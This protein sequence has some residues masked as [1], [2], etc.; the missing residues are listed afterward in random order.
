MRYLICL[1]FFM[2]FYGSSVFAA[3]SDCDR[4]ASPTGGGTGLTE[5]S[6]FQIIDFWPVIMLGSVDKLCLI[7]GTYTGANSMIDPNIASLSGTAVN[8]ITIE[9]I[10]HGGCYI[11]GEG[12]RRPIYLNENSYFHIIGVNA[13]DSSENVVTLGGSAVP[14][15]SIIEKGV[16]WDMGLNF[17]GGVIDGGQTNNARISD[18]AVWGVGR[19]SLSTIHS[20]NL[21][22]QRCWFRWEGTGVIGTTKT[23]STNRGTETGMILENIIATV[24][25]DPAIPQNG[26]YRGL[27]SDTAVNPHIANH[28]LLGSIGLYPSDAGITGQAAVFHRLTSSFMYENIAVFVADNIPAETDSFSFVNQTP[29]L[30]NV[31]LDGYTSIADNPPVFGSDYFTGSNSIT[32]GDECGSNGVGCS[33]IFTSSVG[34]LIC[35]KYEDGVQTAMPLWPLP[36]TQQ[37]IDAMDFAGETPVDITA[38]VESIFGTIPSQCRSDTPSPSPPPAGPL[39]AEFKA[40]TFHQGSFGG[41]SSP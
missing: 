12:I 40:G 22:V 11:N 3:P 23:I 24:K 25:K 34:A 19:R 9:C 2:F 27:Y 6:P 36:I 1:I 15:G 30:T 20:I 17:N 7:T 10:T 38:D 16:F 14:T 18:C 31:V 29:D 33:S 41:Q 5:G 35:N 32:N 8:P 37:L 4:Y 21:H 39:N 13:Y 28:K 26:T